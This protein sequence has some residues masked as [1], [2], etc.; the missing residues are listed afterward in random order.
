MIR[1]E[2]KHANDVKLGVG[3]MRIRMDYVRDNLCGVIRV[4]VESYPWIM[5][6]QHESREGDYINSYSSR[7]LPLSNTG[8]APVSKEDYVNEHQGENDV[9]DLESDPLMH[10]SSDSESSKWSRMVYSKLV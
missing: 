8:A 10:M 7:S 3:M 9:D 5:G 1:K 2:Y 4:S 6:A